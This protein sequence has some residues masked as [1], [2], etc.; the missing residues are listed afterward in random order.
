MLLAWNVVQCADQ[1][2]K[3]R[4]RA[5][6]PLLTLS[7]SSLPLPAICCTYPSVAATDSCIESAPRERTSRYMMNHAS[8]LCF[9]TMY[10]GPCKSPNRYHLTLRH[11]LGI[12]GLA[13]LCGGL[14]LAYCAALLPACRSSSAVFLAACAC[15]PG[16]S[17]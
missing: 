10:P 1:A 16:A 8:K 2:L 15:N 9:L 12:L 14:T 5:P 4:I 17:M 6:F 3:G 11:L 7:P 13:C